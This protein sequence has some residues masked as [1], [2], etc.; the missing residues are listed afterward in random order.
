MSTRI[1][2]RQLAAT[3]LAAKAA[4]AQAPASKYMGA[5]DNFTAKVD[6]KKLDPVAYS[7]QRWDAAPR[8]L[9]F[10]AKSRRDAEA[11]QKR[12]RPKV[13]ELMGGFPKE[14]PPVKAQTLE[15]K[16]YPRFRRETVVFESR[17]GMTVFGYLLTPAGA[18]GAL[19]T[20]VCYPGHGRGVD[21]IVG[22]DEKGG[23]RTDK[24]GYQHDFA[25]QVVEMGLAAFAI[26]PAG[27]GCR[28][29]A[30]AFKRNLTQSSCLPSGGAA[31]LLGETIIGWRV[32][33]VMRSL[34]WLETRPEVDKTRFG[35]AG[36]SGGGMGTMFAA[37]VDGRIKAS[38]VSGYLCT[39]RDSIVSLSHCIDNYLPGV[40]NYA[41][42][43]DIAG[44]IAPR[45]F[46][47]E[48]GEKDNIFPV[49][50]ARSAF[51]EVEKIYEVFGAAEMAGHEVH[52]HAHIFHGV[53]GLPF[54][55]R[56]LKA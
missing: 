43:S 7:L 22:I 18:R 30:I 11:W 34:D 16:S 32:F 29:D 47:A 36:I 28:R 24:D 46:F 54:L 38:L 33:D 48:S 50:A 13:V 35:C 17:P 8:A 20:V 27:F 4:A 9:R 1:T 12:L 42:M 14:R 15:V 55:A 6:M 19:P 56:Q 25:L 2:R 45:A 39:F 40:L 5:M 49:A 26:E 44:L 31:L 3:A 53:E 51:A 21:D 10:Q 23:D 37:A 52:P 41:E